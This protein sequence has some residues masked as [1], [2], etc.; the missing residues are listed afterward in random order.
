MNDAFNLIL[1][2]HNQHYMLEKVGPQLPEA[3]RPCFEKAIESQR[4]R[5]MPNC[6]LP[7]AA[8]TRRGVV[9]LGDALNMRHPLTGGMS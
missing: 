6:H 4:I 1:G 5:M 8:N 3:V 2:P 7:A 9:V